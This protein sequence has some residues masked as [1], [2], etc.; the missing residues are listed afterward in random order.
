MKIVLLI[1]MFVFSAAKADVTAGQVEDMLAQM[2]NENII[3]AKEAEKAKIKLKAMSPQQWKQINQ[4]AKA[5][6]ARS[7]ASVVPVNNSLKDASA[8]DLDGAQFK[9]IQDDMK[10][11]VPAYQGK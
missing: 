11:I 1:C 10:R 6:A 4:E 5:I 7:P 2:V 8:I 3:S 9:Q